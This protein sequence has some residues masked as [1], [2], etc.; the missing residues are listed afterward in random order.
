MKYSFRSAEK[1]NRSGF[2]IVELIVVIVV[3]L[4]MSAGIAI[5][6]SAWIHWTQFKEQNDYARTL[7]GIAQNQLTEYSAHG[8][9]EKKVAGRFRDDDG[10]DHHVIDFDSLGLIDSKGSVID[11]DTLW[12]ARKNKTEKSKYTGKVCY[13]MGT[14]Q[15]FDT[16]RSDPDALDEQGK[17]EVRMMYD[18]LVP[19]LSDASILEAV[20]CVELTPEDGQVYSVL[21]SNNAKNKGHY[22]QYEDSGVT[23]GQVSIHSRM[24]DYR[25]DRMVGYYGVGSLSLQTGVNAEKP[26]FAD[27]KLNNEETLNFSFRIDEVEESINRMTYTVGVYDK[28]TKKK[29]MELLVDG[30]KLDPPG[31]ETDYQVLQ[32]QLIRYKTDGAKWERDKD[33]TAPNFI[34]VLVRQERDNTIRLVLDGADLTASS[35]LYRSV[36]DELTDGDASGGG[37]S[38]YGQYM[39][40]Y[41]F[42]RFGVD[43]EEIYCTV[44]GAGSVYKTTAKK[45]SNSSSVY[46]EARAKQ[47]KEKADGT[48][49]EQTVYTIG[50]GRHLYNIR[51]V[52]DRVVPV[53][54][55]RTYQLSQDI[56]WKS[57]VG[58]GLYY[59]STIRT[60][61]STLDAVI[62]TLTPDDSGTVTAPDVPFPSVGILGKD[63]VFTSKKVTAA[64][65]SDISFR[66][67]DNRYLR[68][69]AEVAADGSVSQD[70]KSGP[71]G[72][73]AVNQGLIENVAFDRAAVLGSD[74]AGTV[75][76]ENR[77]DLKTLTVKKDSVVEGNTNVGGIAGKDAAA[78]PRK[79][80][81]LALDNYAAVTGVE[82]VGGIV[83]QIKIA[84]ASD[85]IQVENCRNYGVVEAKKAAGSAPADRARAKYIG[86]IAGY[87]ENGAGAE[88]NLKFKN[89]SGCPRYSTA[90]IEE[91]LQDESRLQE[92]LNGVYVGGII[93]YNKG[94]KL[95]KCHGRNTSAAKSYLFGYKYV[96]GI[97]GFNEGAAG[98]SLDGAAGI[99]D[100]N[101]IGDSYVGG[102]CGVN[103][104]L[105]GNKDPED[106]VPLPDPAVDME[107][108]VVNWINQGVIAAA[109]GYAGGITGYNTGKI[110]ECESQVSLND[111]AKT[112]TDV[113]ALQEGNYIGGI[114]GYNGGSVTS[115]AARD[116][117]SYLTGSDYIG[118]VAGYNDVDAELS[119]YNL[120][121]GY[122]KG[123]G[124]F[125]GGLIGLNASEKLFASREEAAYAA[126]FVASPNEVSGVFCVGGFIGGNIVP[127]GDDQARYAQ[128][129]VDNF[130][131]TISAHA[132]AGGQIGYNRLMKTGFTAAQVKAYA[133]DL[134]RQG[135]DILKDEENSRDES[136]RQNL[137]ILTEDYK[138][139]VR[140][141]R[142]LDADEGIADRDSGGKLFIVGGTEQTATRLESVTGWNYMGGIVGYN[143]ENT[144]LQIQDMISRTPVRAALFLHL[145]E[146]HPLDEGSTDNNPF[147][148]YLY[149]YSG[150]IICKVTKNATLL[151]C[152]NQGE[153]DVTA[154]GKYLGGI[155]E[156]NEGLVKDCP[157]SSVGAS[158]KSYVGGIAGLNKGTIEGCYFEKDTVVIGDSYVGGIAAENFGTIAD[159][160]LD[161]GAV[162][163]YGVSAGGVAA[164]NYGIIQFEEVTEGAAAVSAAEDYAGGIVAQNMQGT[165]A[166]T[167]ESYSGRLQA[168]NGSV[169]TFAGSVSGQ[170]YTGGIVGMNF[171]NTALSKWKN[172]ATVVAEKG[173]AGGIA[174][175]GVTLEIRNCENTGTIIAATSGEAGGITA[176]I[177]GKDILDCVNRG[178]VSAENG[179]GSA[180]GIVA[181]SEGSRIQNCTVEGNEGD[182]VSVEGVQTAGGIIGVLGY[183]S[184]ING[185]RVEQALVRNTKNSGK[186]LSG[187]YVGGLVGEE[188]QG[189]TVQESTVINSQIR[190]CAS[191]DMI[192][193]GG[194]VGLHC[195]MGSK[196]TVTDCTIALSDGA[197]YGNL[198]GIAGKIWNGGRLQ[199]STVLADI[200]GNMGSAG[201]GY[202]G[203]VGSA[204]NGSTI[205]SC[206]YSG[207]V[208]AYGSSDNMVSLGGIAGLNNV[209]CVI[210]NCFIGGDRNTVI[211]C[212]DEE[213]KKTAAGHVGGIVGQNSGVVS[214]SGVSG[215]PEKQT[216]SVTVIDCIGN[217]GGVIGLQN[218]GAWVE[219]S[220]TGRNWTVESLWYVSGTGTGGI[221]GYCVSGMDIKGCRNYADVSSDYLDS[222]NVA[223]GGLIGRLENNQKNGMVVEDFINYGTITGTL[224]GGAVGRIKYK[225]LTFDQCINYGSVISSD[226]NGKSRGAGGLAGN[227]FVVKESNDYI[228]FTSCENH[229]NITGKR[230]VGGIVGYTSSD[231][232]VDMMFS[233]CVNSG[234]LIITPVDDNNKHYGGMIAETGASGQKVS[235]YRCRNYGNV[236]TKAKGA[237]SITVKN[238][239]DRGMLETSKGT[240]TVRDCFNFSE[241]GGVY[242][243]QQNSYYINGSGTGTKLTYDKL[244]ET[245]RR[246]MNGSKEIVGGFRYDYSKE[247][248]YKDYYKDY[249][250]YDT[251]Y[252]TASQARSAKL[253]RQQ[254]VMDVDPHVKEYY[255][256]LST[257]I[258]KVENVK[259]TNTGGRLVV[260]WTH[261]GTNYEAD[262]LLYKIANGLWMSA[263]NVST[264]PATVAYG[265]E[266]FVIQLNNAKDV[267]IAIRS[268][269]SGYS[270]T[271]YDTNWRSDYGPDSGKTESGATA[272]VIREQSSLLPAQPTPKVHIEL[273]PTDA[274][275]KLF[276]AVL[277]NV[278]D[279][280]GDPDTVI[281]VSGLLGVKN[282]KITF[283]ASAGR[284]EPFLIDNLKNANVSVTAKGTSAHTDSLITTNVVALYGNDALAKEDYVVTSFMDFYGSDMDGISYRMQ[285]DN[286]TTTEENTELYMDTELVVDDY[287]IG[288][289]AAGRD[290]RL[291]VAVASGNSHVTENGGM[292]TSVLNQLP[293]DFLNYGDLTVR[294]YPW[295][296]QGNVC[297]YGHPVQS[298]I[299]QKNLLQY[300]AD[301]SLT[302]T[303]RKVPVFVEK[304][305]SPALNNGY[306]LRMNENG[307][308]SVI[309][310]S[311][312]GYRDTYGRQID[313]KVYKVDQ[314]NGTVTSEDYSAKIW[315]APVIEKEMLLSEDGSQYTFQWDLKNA[316]KSADYEVQLVGHVKKT[317][318]TDEKDVVLGRQQVDASASDDPLFTYTF[319]D[320]DNSWSYADLTLSVERKGIA[321]SAGRTTVFPSFGKEDFTV[322]LRFSQIPRPTLTLH[323]ENDLVEKDTLLY[324][325]KWDTVYESQRSDVK[326]Y[327]VRVQA[328]NE[329]G[330]WE[331]E[332]LTFAAEDAGASS[333]T[334]Q[335]DL[336]KYK[337]GQTLRFAV[338]ALAKEDA[339]AYR[340]GLWGVV[341]E[342][343]L[344][345]RQPTPDVTLM[346]SDPAYME[347]QEGKT[348]TYMTAE[349]FAD[350]LILALED[351][352][353]AGVQ[354]RYELAAAV[355]EKR[356]DT[357]ADTGEGRDR[358]LVA[359]GDAPEKETETVYW[360]TGAEKTLIE[361]ASKTTMS[362]SLSD[363]S[364][365]LTEGL[366]EKD[367]GKW[368][369]IVLRNVSDSNVSSWWSDE[370]PDGET[371]NYCWLR[372]PR[373]QAGDIYPTE[374]QTTLYYNMRTNQWSFKS[375]SGGYMAAVTQTTLKFAPAEQ[376][377]SIRIQRAGLAKNTRFADDVI[378]GRQDVDWI[379]LEPAEGK[380]GIYNVFV[381]STQD[382]F[383]EAAKELHKASDPVCREDADAVFAGEL[384]AGGYVQLPV[385]D[386]VLFSD[387]DQSEIA[388]ATLLTMTETEEGPVF[389][390][391]LPDGENV[392]VSG[393]DFA[394]PVNY[395]TAQI[396]FQTVMLGKERL[397]K[398]ESGRISNWQRVT[399]RNKWS[400]AVTFM[401]TYGAPVQ[402]SLATEASPLRD[403]AYQ[404]RTT[405]ENRQ[406]YQVTLLDKDQKTVLDRRYLGA[407][408]YESSVQ[409]IYLLL[410]EALYGNYQGYYITLKGAEIVPGENVTQWSRETKPILLPEIA[411]PYMEY[412]IG[413]EETEGMVIRQEGATE[414]IAV[415]GISYSW[416]YDPMRDAKINGYQVQIGTQDAVRYIL[417]NSPDGWYYINEQG[418]AVL[419]EGGV[420]LFEMTAQATWGASEESEGE[421]ISLKIPVRLSAAA[422]KDGS[423]QFVLTLPKNLTE[424]D[425]VQENGGGER[426]SFAFDSDSMIEGWT[427]FPQ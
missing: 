170:Q 168:E 104:R 81:Y 13:C 85:E 287:V 325:I 284:S 331:E 200:T 57:F 219:N 397:E 409:E 54:Y 426:L 158:N 12:P 6:I 308:Y 194:A 10:N 111:A 332:I 307:S 403:M 396:S 233:D 159:A 362:G 141:L 361:K 3:L 41:S 309:Y 328:L 39:N 236:G 182:P 38:E 424:L 75:C 420:Q 137:N 80:V 414:Q 392:S 27:V 254:F 395:R 94:A 274:D 264:T 283:K 23:R 173:T 67:D 64:E 115:A 365:R 314:K 68:L 196:I 419:L 413:E 246:F 112:I 62:Q 247:T 375:G 347:H 239:S 406:V 24:A 368:L 22:F 148:Q 416:T 156:I 66:E 58:K 384:S 262:Q 366:D 351:P 249:Q 42:S 306:V 130:L 374:G 352:E 133:D 179:D 373:I 21:Y 201:S 216:Y 14:A 258:S 282:E 329:D 89:C 150:G 116:I 330:S 255:D 281:E 11:L 356:P 186:I 195:A 242:K 107:I 290:V 122:V 260:T 372:I 265:V 391:I 40:T 286:G 339:A 163:A 382:G 210:Q 343:T 209:G 208:Q 126:P 379:Y 106:Q 160:R 73:F 342:M 303:E 415:P 135:E 46:F 175:Q 243:N 189:V 338:R 263:P 56:N 102:I 405:A 15:D 360:N 114:V 202:G 305:G 59:T 388:V 77:G 295:Q 324:D 131:G 297:W 273:T 166:Y 90:A 123:T 4:I 125:V 190:A 218:P 353:M 401:E 172:T 257:S 99:T 404:V 53:T 378:Y 253:Y 364:Y 278:S 389:A 380:N 18:M 142:A 319:T 120:L 2:T 152:E 252:K 48:A 33:D 37:T 110:A 138:A 36:Y 279:Y 226:K 232:S 32:C 164:A 157:V 139:A 244:S 134:C 82:N 128:I 346:T 91:I 337:P 29:R 310:S 65:I 412:Q 418:E 390:L 215:N 369:K 124:S 151:R 101:V 187:S 145:P 341:R 17:Q 20:V 386:S 377:D 119:G 118:G 52:E 320:E 398:Y 355:Y 225:G 400:T 212:G 350:G 269:G 277:E 417:G 317:A 1:K 272:W 95:E 399:N 237:S 140:Y 162:Q 50:N 370:D 43:A 408:S 358:S 275:K 298:N 35:T 357:E 259:V 271:T 76:G 197:A 55:D 188:K 155:C 72:L 153:G 97:V 132:F 30:S 312:L 288:Q 248:A 211:A 217:T 410:S 167:R 184:H 121:G 268:I 270:R 74:G 293:Q 204:A 19:Y 296:S 256:T 96:G 181:G 8:Q 169:Y 336:N 267:K 407:Y 313:E 421:T 5:G 367:A 206:S 220:I 103:G 51:Y 207:A 300:A 149:S 31:S 203:I 316:D 315:A 289:D 349:E 301:Q 176:H 105:S 144:K 385:T 285:L 92:K 326:A 387:N 238:D 26:S 44:Q 63:A 109:G 231:A 129:K 193:A 411:A 71:V 185:C 335:V 381:L 25:Y 205:E 280:K 191:G 136:G 228:A 402:I 49:G 348:D 84:G 147:S 340:D 344:P 383:P 251:S 86:G 321:D 376:G 304:D 311:I 322:K 213:T 7:Y 427:Y 34:P 359:A 171:S 276:T 192:C 198:G 299:S 16:Y 180:G 78:S 146:E 229:G 250:E 227:F 224:T 9:L 143:G 183:S 234:A 214:G 345:V 422:Q 235:F 113:A 423:V 60:P 333:M 83:G 28:E 154:T 177:A 394:N 292:V 79:G 363:A 47:E 223:V 371:M 230:D 393:E 199:N 241:G 88:E 425:I 327:Q 334:R 222:D 93:G 302:D 174:G 294:S 178:N 70:S 221:I 127:L 69:Y 240:V 98:S 108:Q 161:G 117:V 45:Q 266:R 87:A 261:S 61:D 318:S 245:Y 165:N 291:P 323:R 100:I 354:G